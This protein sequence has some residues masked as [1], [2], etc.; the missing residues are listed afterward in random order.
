MLVI[1]NSPDLF[2]ASVNV[3]QLNSA[4][5]LHIVTQQTVDNSVSLSQ[6][7]LGASSRKKCLSKMIDI[8]R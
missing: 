4:V 7:R 1:V 2:K 5:P 6:W 8:S 3:D